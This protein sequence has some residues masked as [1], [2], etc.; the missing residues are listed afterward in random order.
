MIVIG[1]TGAIAAG[2]S[3]TAKLFGEAGA[4]TFDADAAVH[5]LYAGGETADAVAAAFPGAA[6]PGGAVSR[7][8]LGLAVVN[9]TAALE[10][11]EAIIHPAVAREEAA[12]VA[13]T[14]RAGALFAVLDIPLLFE[15]GR[16][17]EVD[18]VVVAT[19]PEGLRRQRALARP[20][21]TA[22]KLAALEGR[23]LAA[24]EKARRAHFLV[25]TGTTQEAA[26]RAVRDIMRALV[27]AA[28]GR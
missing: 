13:R 14:G 18:V 15:T 4:A 26:R 11:L 16:D 7:P 23:Q 17:R 12:F 20:A 27:A 22:E 3:A 9:D 28:A 21:M 10:R 19:A 8:H 1:L 2:K 6:L 24:A 25:D 5:R